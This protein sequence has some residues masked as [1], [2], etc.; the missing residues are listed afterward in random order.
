MI[1]T[2]CIKCG[3]V[4]EKFFA[5]EKVCIICHQHEMFCIKEDC[6]FCN[7][8]KNQKKDK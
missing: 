4:F 8:S 3:R 2:K 5:E 7:Q 1:T 6:K